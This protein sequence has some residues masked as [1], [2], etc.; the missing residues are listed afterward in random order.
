M[1]RKAWKH[2]QGKNIHNHSP[3]LLPR[4]MGRGSTHWTL[5]S[6]RGSCKLWAFHHCHRCDP[7]HP[8]KDVMPDSSVSTLWDSLSGLSASSSCSALKT[9]LYQDRCSATYTPVWMHTK[10]EQVLLGTWV[11]GTTHTQKSDLMSPPNLCLLT[12]TP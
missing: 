2:G 11:T 12:G 4:T 5:G 8:Q 3:V 10:G 6:N 9:F 7:Q 1:L